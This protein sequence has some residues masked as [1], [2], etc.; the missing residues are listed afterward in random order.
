MQHAVTLLNQPYNS[1]VHIFP[2][3][4]VYQAPDLPMRYWKNGVSK[5]ILE[6]EKA[7]IVIP[8][9]HSGMETVMREYK[10][11][12][13]FIP[14][15]RKD[16][17]VRFGD[18]IPSDVIETLREKW[19]SRPKTDGQALQIKTTETVRDAVNKVRSDMGFPPEP[20]N[21]NDA[22]TFPPITAPARKDVE[23]WFTRARKEGE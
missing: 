11:P 10:V 8:M 20:P 14:S 16:L 21:S 12:P 2:E 17:R 19:R 6:P 1:W 22:K 18:P 7:P 5:L 9:F 13:Q 23:G 15:I 3:A 4:R